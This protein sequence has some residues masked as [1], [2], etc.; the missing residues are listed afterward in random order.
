[1]KILIT[2]GAGYIGSK[3]AYDMLDK[4]YSVWIVDN[5]STGKKRLIPKKAYF[6]KIDITNINKLSKFFINKKFD[7]VF[8][9]AGCLSVSESQKKPLKYLKNNVIGTKNLIEVIIKNNIKYLIFS[10]T[11]AVYGEKKSS[12]VS[13]NDNAFPDSNYGLSKLLA[14]NLIKNYSKHFKFAILRYFNV[15]GADINN[16]TGLC[17]N[18][19]LFK[20][21]ANNIS[22]KKYF[23]NIFGNDYLT[24]DG[25]CVRDYI[26]VNDLSDIH[27]L[28]YQKL[29]NHDSFVLNCGYNKGISVKEVVKNF[30]KVIKFKIKIYLKKRRDGDVS[31]IYS[32]NKKMNKIFKNWSRKIDLETS[33]KK[34][35]DWEKKLIKLKLK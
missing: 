6:S 16:R 9:F 23:L 32:N 14:E 19:T 27:F 20:N 18:G 5:L 33:I 7:A 11:C 35:L 12:K 8:H 25:T 30:E 34:M 31:S 29:Y 17:N 21:L 15:V 22:K 4:G 24:K 2:G 1:M 26:D 13:E 28:S 10:S 3:F